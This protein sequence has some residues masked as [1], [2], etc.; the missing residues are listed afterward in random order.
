MAQGEGG[1]GGC[2]L[3]R[4]SEIKWAD[5]GISHTVCRNCLLVWTLDSSIATVASRA[6]GPRGAQVARKGIDEGSDWRRLATI[7][8]Q[9]GL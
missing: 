3:G 9:I 4:L 8:Q 5:E 2:V 1:E 6:C 7:R